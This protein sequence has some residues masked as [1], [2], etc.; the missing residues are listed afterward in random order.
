MDS[1]CQATATFGGATCEIFQFE[2][3]KK[4]NT[5]YYINLF[6]LLWWQRRDHTNINL[7]KNVRVVQK[8]N[9]RTVLEVKARYP[10]NIR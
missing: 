3:Q 1:P 10:R 5:R 7:V 4:S 2:K 9:S 8:M 6:E